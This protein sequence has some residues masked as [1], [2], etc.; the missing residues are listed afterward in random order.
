MKINKKIAFIGG[1]KM[2]EALIKGLISSKVLSPGRI[3]A[4]DKSKNRRSLLK[5][6][7]KI[8]VG[9]KNVPAVLKAGVI[10]LCVKPQVI[11]AVLR[12]IGPHIKSGQL[13]ISIA[14][15]IKISSIRK[16]VG[17]APVIRVMPNN[18][19]LVGEGISAIASPGGVGRANLKIAESIFSSV[20]GVVF[21]PEKQ[22]DAVTALSGSGPAFV[23]LVAEALISGGRAVKLGPSASRKL[24]VQTML[25][26]VAALIESGK[27]PEELRAMVT[28]P[29]GTTL[30]GLKVLT[31][32]KFKKALVSAI[33]AAAKRSEQLGRQYNR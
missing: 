5:S 29:G 11:N 14:A 28:S 17:R 7:Y 24:A 6:M 18:P 21:L 32:F 16:F 4:S 2:A 9:S 23:Y 3:F 12:E 10:V 25:G 33:M 13:V 31:K 26:S 8:K 30:A 19:C 27:S 1:G 15:G 22:M 20:G